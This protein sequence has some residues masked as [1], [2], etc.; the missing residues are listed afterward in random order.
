MDLYHGSSRHFTQFD[1]SRMGEGIGASRLT[2]GVNLTTHPGLAEHYRNEVT[3][4][5]TQHT[6]SGFLAGGQL[7]SSD[8]NLSDAEEV[9]GAVYEVAGVDRN[10][11]LVWEG[12]LG[13]QTFD[14][15]EL[16]QRLYTQEELDAIEELFEEAINDEHNEGDINLVDTVSE[17]VFLRGVYGCRETLAE[18]NPGFDW[19]RLD[20]IIGDRHPSIEVD[21]EEVGRCIYNMVASL[22]GD[23]HAGEWF[24]KNDIQGLVSQQEFTGFNAECELVV[25]WDAESLKIKSVLSSGEIESMSMNLEGQSADYARPLEM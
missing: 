12:G 13:S 4:P 22:K 2:K 15:V 7:Y 19:D 20:T 18:L 17:E 11:L 6:D 5:G 10:K 25:V 23:E 14:V 21:E 1:L 9:H 8:D 24:V 3:I 16:I